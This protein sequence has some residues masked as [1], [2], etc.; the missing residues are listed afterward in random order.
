[1]AIEDEIKDV[2]QLVV[3]QLGVA[4]GLDNSIA[5]GQ[6]TPAKLSTGAPEWNSGGAFFTKGG[7]NELNSGVVGDDFTYLDFH[8]TSASNPDYDAR[9][10]KSSGVDGNFNIMNK[11]SGEFRLHQDDRLKFQ[12]TPTAASL[13]SNS[14]QDARISCY[15]SD[16]TWMP[17]GIQYT[18]NKHIFKN[19]GQDATSSIHMNMTDDGDAEMVIGSSDSNSEAI[20]KVSSYTP[21]IRLEDKTTGSSDFQLQANSGTLSLFSGDE[22]GDDP[23]TNNL[24]NIDNTGKIRVGGENPQGEQPYVFIHGTRD[25]ATAVDRLE[26]QGDQVAIMSSSNY[27]TEALKVVS[28][29]VYVPNG[30]LLIG[31]ESTS[32]TANE[33]GTV[34]H[35]DGNIFSA[36][37]GN[38]QQPHIVFMNNADTNVNIVG[39]IQSSGSSTTFYTNSD[40]RLKED[41][42]DMEGSIERLKD[43]KPVNFKWKSDGTRVDGFIAHEA[44]EVVPE[45]VG[46]TKDALNEEGNPEY[47]GIDQSKLVPLLTKALQEAVAK[48]EA[49]EARITALEA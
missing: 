13:L 15:A 49:L 27:A 6:V 29:T 37:D 35:R 45:A 44:Q 32:S 1:M 9:I 36:R 39:S 11:G 47:Q 46:G 17:S 28:S 41:I 19:I 38:S 12:A 25:S 40:Y 16:S 2:Q 43:L 33:S 10:S 18:A 30:A 22:S 3:N 23:L 31:R 42:V 14:Y 20:L 5:D 21:S 8:S 34:I 7:Q 26:L 24:L 48:I 4:N